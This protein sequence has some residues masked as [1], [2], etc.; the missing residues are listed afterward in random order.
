MGHK[1]L[2]PGLVEFIAARFKALGEPARLRILDSLRGGPRTVT[3]LVEETRLRQANVSKHLAILRSLGL[4]NRRREGELVYFT[5]ADVRLSSLCDLMCGQ[6]KSEPG[7]RGQ[8][9]ARRRGR[10]FA[11]N[12][13]L[14]AR[15]QRALG[16]GRRYDEWFRTPGP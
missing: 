2:T 5:V 16:S 14:A 13:D 11:P 12:A 10:C 7:G 9:V 1:T 4:V 6:S 15:T 8:A 3:Q